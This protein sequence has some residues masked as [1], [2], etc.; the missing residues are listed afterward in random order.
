MGHDWRVWQWSDKTITGACWMHVSQSKKSPGH[1][2]ETTS[3]YFHRRQKPPSRSESMFTVCRR[4]WWG[5][6]EWSW[7][8]KRPEKSATSGGALGVKLKSYQTPEGL[9]VLLAE[10]ATEL[11]EHIFP[12]KESL[13]VSTQGHGQTRALPAWRNCF[14]DIMFG[15]LLLILQSYRK[16]QNCTFNGICLQ[17]DAVL[18]YQPKK[19]MP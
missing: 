10:K 12:W 9:F 8:N 19:F 1:A 17:T 11:F 5:E 16:L 4:L 18:L 2:I 13:A 6:A 14:L 3:Q 15:I 7:K